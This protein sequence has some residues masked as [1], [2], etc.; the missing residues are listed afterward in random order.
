MLPL[1]SDLPLFPL[2]TVL[3]PG[4]LLPLRVFEARYLDMTR[5]CLRDKTPFGV[6]LLKTGHE[7]AS[8][9]HGQRGQ[10][11]AEPEAIG[12]LAEIIDCD[13]EQLGVLLIRCRGTQRFRLVSSQYQKDGLLRGIAQPIGSD[14]VADENTDPDHLLRLASCA[15][16]LARIIDSARERDVQNMPFLEPFLLEDASWVSNR[17][18]EVLPISMRAR[19]Q[20]ME[21]EDA[22]TRIEL[23]HQYMRRNQLL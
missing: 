11:D 16:V 4:G 22:P 13:M 2:G 19:Q 14:A 6:A 8:L 17:L 20:M 18:A 3:F 23:V 5:A 12:C 1:I 9:K 7:V 21:L 15:E 10:N